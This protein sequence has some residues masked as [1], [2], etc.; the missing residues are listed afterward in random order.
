MFSGLTPRADWFYFTFVCS[1][2]VCVCVGQGPMC[3]LSKERTEQA[4]GLKRRR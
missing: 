4:L 2:C 3:K 1:V